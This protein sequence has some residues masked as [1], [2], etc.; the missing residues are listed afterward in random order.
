MITVPV[1]SPDAIH[2]PTGHWTV[3]GPRTVHQSAG[4]RTHSVC[5]KYIEPANFSRDNN[6]EKLS[7]NRIAL[8]IDCIFEMEL[9]PFG[10]NAATLTC[11]KEPFSSRGKTGSL[12]INTL[13]KDVLSICEN[14]KVTL[15]LWPL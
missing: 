15:A 12:F 7:A 8:N 10:E 3:S 5:G 14:P 11:L 13:I 1:S 6:L 4:A 9:V 2:S